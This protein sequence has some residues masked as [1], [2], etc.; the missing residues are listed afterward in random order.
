METLGGMQEQDG[1]YLKMLQA[2]LAPL[3]S[4]REC[5]SQSKHT[6]KIHKRKLISTIINVTKLYKYW[7]CGLHGQ[8]H[9]I[10]YNGESLHPIH[11]L[12]H[13]CIYPL[14]SIATLWYFYVGRD[15]YN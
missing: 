8:H 7:T 12:N 10:V 2:A 11:L 14:W 5:Q 3:A 9:F 13:R 4:T 1:P 6:G 15:F